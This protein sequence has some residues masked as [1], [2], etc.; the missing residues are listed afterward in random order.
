MEYSF[1]KIP[2]TLKAIFE[3]LTALEERIVNG[4]H[5]GENIRLYN[6]KEACRYLNICGKTL[7]NYRDKSVIEFSQQG[8]K[9]TYT[10]ANL[11]MFLERTKISITTSNK[12]QKNEKYH[13]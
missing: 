12:N 10:Q 2:E 4:E 7:Q 6:N 11:D 1:D 9:I 5:S 13:H 8:R 3:K